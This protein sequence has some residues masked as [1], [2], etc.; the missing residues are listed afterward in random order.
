M[1]AGEPFVWGATADECAARYPCDAYAAAPQHRFFR[2]VDIDAPPAVTYRWLQ[3]LRVAPYSYDWADNFGLPS[4]SRLSSRAERIAVGQRMMHLFSI[5]AFESGRTLTLGPA[6]RIGTAL[7]G[8]LYGTYVVSPRAG[9]SRLLVKVNATYPRSL[10]GRLVGGVMPWIDL[11]MMR[12]QLRRLKRYA[13]ETAAADVTAI[14]PRV[15]DIAVTS[16]AGNAGSFEDE[17]MVRP[18]SEI[19]EYRPPA[20]HRM[21]D[22]VS[23]GVPRLT[24]GCNAAGRQSKGFSC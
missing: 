22:L 19:S 16:S 24:G 12:E 2:A 5:R 18:R 13:E 3:Q 9:G 21:F 4:P 7:F 1:T 6:S 8:E 10:F 11:V 14:S 23:W 17:S 15:T 20:E